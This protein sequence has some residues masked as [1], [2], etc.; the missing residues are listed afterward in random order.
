M[1]ENFGNIKPVP[2]EEQQAIARE[3]NAEEQA[4]REANER[5]YIEAVRLREEAPAKAKELLAQ[6]LQ[7]YGVPELSKEEL[8]VLPYVQQMDRIEA[9]IKALTE[10]K[11]ELDV[12]K[13]G[14][15]E[16][17]DNSH[18]FLVDE[19]GRM[20]Q[21]EEGNYELLP[22]IDGIA[23]RVNHDELRG[24]IEAVLDRD[25]RDAA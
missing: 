11:D 21:I 25:R 15:T 20:L 14:S 12:M 4:E 24:A 10:I 23:E 19:I 5:K 17:L 16:A 2:S 1:R 6:K 8:N 22:S 13:K 18:R 7:A 3:S 9:K